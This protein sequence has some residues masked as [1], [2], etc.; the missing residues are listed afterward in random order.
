MTHLIS[1]SCTSGSFVKVL[2][3]PKKFSFGRTEIHWYSGNS[4]PKTLFIFLKRLCLLALSLLQVH[5]FIDIGYRLSWQFFHLGA[6]K[7]QKNLAEIHVEKSH[8]FSSHIYR[9]KENLWHTATYME[10]WKTDTVIHTFTKQFLCP[11]TEPFT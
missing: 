6:T 2:L 11:G 5:G 8:L 7:K 10:Q 9:S 1:T 3:K 4:Y